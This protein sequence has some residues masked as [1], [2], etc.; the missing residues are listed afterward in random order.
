[1]ALSIALTSLLQKHPAY[2][3]TAPHATFQPGSDLMFYKADDIRLEAAF[4]HLGASVCQPTRKCYITLFLFLRTMS[5]CSNLSLFLKSRHGGGGDSDEFWM[6]FSG[7]F[8]KRRSTVAGPKCF[9]KISSRTERSMTCK[10]RPSI[11]LGKYFFC[12]DWTTSLGK[13]IFST[14]SMLKHLTFEAASLASDAVGKNTGKLNEST[15]SSS[16][17][18]CKN[19]K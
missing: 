1:M 3:S 4:C 17:S 5:R 13:R 6:T 19:S 14:T 8:E 16:T 18:P 12:T 10:P 2:Y 7:S 9:L 15:T 11:S